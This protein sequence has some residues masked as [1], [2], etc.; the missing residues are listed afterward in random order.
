MLIQLWEDSLSKSSS[1]CDSE[2][3]PVFTP[4]DGRFVRI[5]LLGND[6]L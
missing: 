2:V 3:A 5:V 4:K 6:N 1:L